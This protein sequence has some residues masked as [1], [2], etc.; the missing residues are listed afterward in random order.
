MLYIGRLLLIKV[1]D[2]PPPKFNEM[3]RT[4]SCR[5]EMLNYYNCKKQNWTLVLDV[6]F[7]ASLSQL[8]VTPTTVQLKYARNSP[9]VY[10]TTLRYLI[11]ICFQYINFKY[12]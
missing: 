11:H 9:S 4:S 1:V 7:R 10:V 3:N 6:A 5:Q 8:Y 12:I 2:V